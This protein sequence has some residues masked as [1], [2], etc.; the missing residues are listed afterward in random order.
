MQN[1]VIKRIFTVPDPAYY[2]IG[3]TQNKNYQYYITNGSP[4]IA[5]ISNIQT[6]YANA[7]ANFK[8]Y[9]SSCKDP[10]SGLDRELVYLDD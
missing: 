7:V 1:N 4:F 6:R 8:L 2:S 10:A 9:I 5:L 3:V